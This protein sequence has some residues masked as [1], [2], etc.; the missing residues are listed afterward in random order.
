MQPEEK[1]KIE[2][3]ILD[4]K[5]Y[6]E[7][8]I[9]LGV[10]SIQD[11]T[12]SVLS[13]IALGFIIGILGV[14]VILFL[15]VGAAWLIGHCINNIACGFFIV[16]GFYLLITLIIFLKRDKWINTPIVNLLLKKINSNEED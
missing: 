8:R 5:E 10:L 3:M 1:S 16:A 15:S 2:K 9:E 13:S 14:F 11:K 7:T 6:A 12:A 4:L